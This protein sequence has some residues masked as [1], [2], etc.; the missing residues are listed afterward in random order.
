MKS[1]LVIK[2]RYW[3]N[4]TCRS[5]RGANYLQYI[6]TR[7]GVEEITPN[8]KKQQVTDRQKKLIQSLIKDIPSIT[9]SEEYDI[10]INTLTRN[11]AR[12][13]ISSVFDEHPY[14]LDKKTYLDYIATRPGVQRIESHGLFSD[15]D[16]DI[17][18]SKEK[19]K[20]IN[21]KGRVNSLIISLSREDAEATGFNCAECWSS[22]MRTRKHELSKCFNI[23]M[24]NLEWYGAF[25]NEPTHPHIHILLYSTDPAYP[26]YII[27]KNL[28]TMKRDFATEIFRHELDSIYEQQKN[29]RNEL[30][31]ISKKEISNL[32]KQIQTS[33]SND[34]TLLSMMRE[35]SDKLKKTKGKKT[36]AFLTPDLKLLVNNITDK[37]TDNEDIR[38]LYDLWY[39]SKYAILRMYTKHLPPKRPLSE[40][41]T[42]KSIRNAIIK[43]AKELEPIQAAGNQNTPLPVTSITGLLKSISN[44]FEQKINEQLIK[45]PELVIDSKLKREIEAKKK[46]QNLG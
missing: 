6:G 17:I 21:F 29:Q 11:T 4:G 16:K 43:A 25:H 35:L 10:Y 12:E 31:Q 26:G 19:E 14:L 41:E 27:Q 37:L 30:T 1:P 23:P 32:I 38:R 18:L 34:P 20:L 40:E 15:K 13:L 5:P 46:G 42:F 3:N 2:W 24:E 9:D 39:E 22:F 44:V 28:T 45:H 8:L 36:Y 33:T 7:D